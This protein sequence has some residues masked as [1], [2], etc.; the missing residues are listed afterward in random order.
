MIFQKSRDHL[1]LTA[2]FMSCYAF[3]AACAE[4]WPVQLLCRV[5]GV[6]PG[7]LLVAAKACR[8]SCAMAVRDAGCL[9]ASRPPVWHP[10]LRAELRAEGHAVGR[11]ALRTW[12]RRKVRA[13][14]TRPYLPQTRLGRR[15]HVLTLGERALMLHIHLTRRLPPVRAR[16]SS[17][18]FNRRTRAYGLEQERPYPLSVAHAPPRQRVGEAPLRPDYCPSPFAGLVK[19]D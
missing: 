4:P 9:H 16:L 13:L 8:R 3:I 11:Y 19:A 15:H 10:R 14:S 2:S 1:F 12:L 6:S 7:L 17:G 18:P 5:L